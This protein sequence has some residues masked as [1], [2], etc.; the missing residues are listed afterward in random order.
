M[1]A[2]IFFLLWRAH[3]FPAALELE[4]E[5]GNWA[6]QAVTGSWSFA[7]STIFIW[8]LY[9]LSAF[10]CEILGIE[11]RNRLPVF[12]KNGWSGHAGSTFSHMSSSHTGEA[13]AWALWAGEVAAPGEC[14]H[15]VDHFCYD[16]CLYLS[17]QR[18]WLLLCKWASMYGPSV[19]YFFAASLL[20]QKSTVAKIKF[21]T[22]L[23]VFKIAPTGRF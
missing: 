3:L 5:V 18:I 21:S 7:W 8:S 22:H 10:Y 19:V 14:L 11:N 17:F 13:P 23:I 15:T 16:H 1:L 12:L 2:V 4:T 9:Y 6:P 20:I